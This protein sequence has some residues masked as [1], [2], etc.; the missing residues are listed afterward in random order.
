MELTYTANADEYTQS[1]KHPKDNSGIYAIWRART[2]STLNVQL[3][4]PLYNPQVYGAIQ[5]TQ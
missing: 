5:S 4:T 2:T 3:A 1:T